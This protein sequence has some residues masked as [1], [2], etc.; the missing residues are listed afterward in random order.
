VRVKKRILVAFT[1]TLFSDFRR[2]LLKPKTD[3]PLKGGGK[4]D[5]KKF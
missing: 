1:L 4:R 2:L 3:L 5:L